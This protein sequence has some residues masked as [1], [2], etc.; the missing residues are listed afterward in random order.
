MRVDYGS[1]FV[2]TYKP[3]RLYEERNRKRKENK[4]RK[5]KRKNEK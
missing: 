5:E 2:T 1:Y 3:N 4:K